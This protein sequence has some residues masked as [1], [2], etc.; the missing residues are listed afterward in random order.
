MRTLQAPF[1]GLSDIARQS[2]GTAIPFPPIFV[3]IMVIAIAICL[4]IAGLLTYAI[5]RSRRQTDEAAPQQQH[6]NNRLEILWTIL[7][8]ILLVAIFIYTAVDTGT[9]PEPGAGIPEGQA[10]DV[11]VIG[12]Q[13]WWEYRYPPGRLHQQPTE[14]VT[15]NVL[16]IPAGRQ[17]LVE[18][19]ASNV[20]HDYWIPQLGQKFDMY[21][22]KVNHL[23]LEAKE[24]GRYPGF[25]AEFCGVQHAWMNILAIAESE[26]QFEQWVQA[27]VSSAE[28]PADIPPDQAALANEGRELFG[29]LACGSCHAIAGTEWQARAGP[30]LT[31]YSSRPTISAGVLEHTPENLALY[32]KNPQ[33]VKPGI[34]MPNYR[35]SDE[36]VQALVAYLESLK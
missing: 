5:L 34:Y 29:R 31:N 27:Q 6:G 16:H 30:S 2:G 23:W 28:A 13:W 15:A 20:Q 36:D 8:V 14:I 10:P 1:V 18:L 11:V 3:V 17:I 33:A 25:C 21:P 26:E 32:L 19:R 9:G 24:P 4:L 12:H 22:G 35:L 7:P